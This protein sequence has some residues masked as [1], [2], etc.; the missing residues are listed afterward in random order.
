MS[1]WDPS[2]APWNWVISGARQTLQDIAGGLETGFV[3]LLKDLWKVLEP[4]V[5]IIAG[6][7]VIYLTLTLARV[8]IRTGGIA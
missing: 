2:W 8:Q 4:A 6:L 7:I 5:E 1:W 3:S